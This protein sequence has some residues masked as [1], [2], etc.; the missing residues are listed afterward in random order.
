MQEG[1]A[2]SMSNLGV[3]QT[4]TTAI[5]AMG[6]PGKAVVKIG[7]GAVTGMVIVYRAGVNWGSKRP[8]GKTIETKIFNGVRSKFRRGTA[9]VPAEMYTATADCNYGGGLTLHAGDTFTAGP[10]ID[11]MIY[12]EVIGNEDNP[13]LVSAQ[14]LAQNS[15]FSLN[16]E[17]EPESHTGG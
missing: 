15:S 14:M 11:E 12:I 4:V 17:K 10:V 13:Y 16:D 5:K 7:A 6:G 1:K 2:N 3:Y 9:E 8:D